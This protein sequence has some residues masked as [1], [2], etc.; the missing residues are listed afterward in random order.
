MKSVGKKKRTYGTNLPGP[1]IAYKSTTEEG[2][3]REAIAAQLPQ[4][5]RFS[6]NLPYTAFELGH[7][8]NFIERLTI[9]VTGKYSEWQQIIPNSQIMVS[10]TQYAKQANGKLNNS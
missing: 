9:E 10:L 5:A 6:L 8:S 7:T 4:S 3:P 2:Y 1:S